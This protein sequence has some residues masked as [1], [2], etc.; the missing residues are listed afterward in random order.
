MVPYELPIEINT[1]N[2][3]EMTIHIYFIFLTP[4]K[5]RQVYLRNTYLVRGMGS[6]IKLYFEQN[7]RRTEEII[8]HVLLIL[9]VGCCVNSSVEILTTRYSTRMLKTFPSALSPALFWA[10][11]GILTSGYRRDLQKR[12][13]ERFKSFGEDTKS[14]QLNQQNGAVYSEYSRFDNQQGR[15]V[16]IF[17]S[18]LQKT[19]VSSGPIE[20]NRKSNRTKQRPSQPF[21]T[22]IY[23]RK[24]KQVKM[25]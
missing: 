20:E 11:S 6:T 7:C 23:N 24:P 9:T 25:K 22:D 19:I 12:D 5:L 4:C 21:V 15:Q 17:Y 10:Q 8:C 2:W 18:P 14:F 13:C 1:V 16:L 3:R